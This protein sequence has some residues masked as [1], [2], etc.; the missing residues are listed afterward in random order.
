LYQTIAGANTATARY[1]STSTIS[2]TTYVYVTNQVGSFDTDYN[3][4]GAESAAVFNIV[5]KYDG[6]L[7]KNTGEVVYIQHGD[8]VSRANTQS[9]IIKLIV[10]F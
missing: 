7:L 10:E 6:D 3:I 1:H 2:G 8:A 9:E 5:T 4:N